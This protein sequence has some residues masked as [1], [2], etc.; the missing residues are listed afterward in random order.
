M[1]HNCMDL[2]RLMVHA[3]HVEESR[4]KRRIHESKKPRF[5]DQ[6]GP[7]SGRSSF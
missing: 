7:S 4:R 5:A 6:A 2:G 3:E 1:F